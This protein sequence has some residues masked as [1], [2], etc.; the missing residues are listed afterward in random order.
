MKISHN[1]KSIQ[2]LWKVSAKKA[3]TY[4]IIEINNLFSS[5]NPNLF[6]NPNYYKDSSLRKLLIVDKNIDILF[7][8]KIEKYFH[9]FGFHISKFIFEASEI[10]KNTKTLLNI[11]KIIDNFNPLRRKEPIIG[12]GGGVLLDILGLASSLYRRGIPYIKVPTTLMGFVDA[13]IGAKTGI[14]YC[15]HKNR[16]GTYYPPEVIYID[17]TF[18]STLSQRQI[19]NGFSEILKIA[20]VKDQNLFELLEKNGKKCLNA[21]LQNFSISRIIIH[22][23]ITDMLQELESNLWES[24]LERLV[25]FGHT[26]SGALEINSLPNLLHGEA[27]SIDM[28]LVSVLSFNRNLLSKRDL[29]RILRVMKILNIPI[30]DPI[31]QPK[32]LIKGL[33]DSTF[34]RDGLQRFPIPIKI[35]KIKFV[36]NVKNEELLIACNTLQKLSDRLL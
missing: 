17:P 33:I 22:K 34:H 26:F 29:F 13:G 5:E 21:K 7:G 31:C 24:S 12:I 6:C 27:V 2:K 10:S 36:N 25:D 14:N 8:N 3:V 11:L 1:Y 20:L 4:S 35:G 15:K 9:K 18:L 16:I 28:A 30:Y 19:S 23:A 32:L